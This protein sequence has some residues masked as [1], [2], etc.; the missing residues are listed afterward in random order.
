MGFVTIIVSYSIRHYNQTSIRKSHTPNTP[1]TPTFVH[2]AHGS[3][4]GE[5]WKWGLRGSS[6][7]MHIGTFM[8]V[9][10]PEESLLLLF[11]VISVA[12][13]T[14]RESSKPP[15]YITQ[16]RHCLDFIPIYALRKRIG[17]FLDAKSNHHHHHHPTTNQMRS[18]ECLFLRRPSPLDPQERQVCHYAC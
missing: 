2:L 17:I 12:K 11:T 6:R 13:H 15:G 18:Q 9:I 8:R 7:Y 1:N 5:P 16:G 10:V 4:F 14:T 3:V